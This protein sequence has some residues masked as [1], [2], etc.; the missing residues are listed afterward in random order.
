M[1]DEAA[2]P[3]RPATGEG[4]PGPAGPSP[5]SGPTPPPNSG[6]GPPPDPPP[7]GTAGFTTRYGLIRPR[8]GRYLAGVCAAIGRAT[9][10]DPILW[11]VLVAV[12]GFFG[13]IGI[14]VYV[15]AW[16]IIPGEGDTASPV[17]AM[18][19]RGRSSTSPVTVL[20]LGI[21]V[22]LGFGYVVTD[23]FRA[24]LL[25]AAILIGGAL[26]INRNTNRNQA[27][28]AGN[29]WSA[30]TGATSGPVPG[31][32]ATPTPTSNL[33]GSAYPSSSYPGSA[34]PGPTSAPGGQPPMAPPPPPPSGLGAT[35][36]STVPA[37]E[38]LSPYLGAASPTEPATLA[39]QAEP[40]APTMPVWPV[41]TSP[42]PPPPAVSPPPTGPLPPAGG[43]R[44]PFAPHGPYANATAYTPGM[45]PM[46]KPPRPP[47][48]PKERSP[49]GAATFSMI[50]VVLGLLA[51]LD[52]SGVISPPP[53]AY[54]AVALATIGLGLLIGTWFGRA[55]W[56]IALGLVAATALGI[57]T[58]A[59]SYDR[60]RN[61]EGDVTW[62]PS[63][64]RDLAIR[65]ENNFGDAVLD[66]TRIEFTDSETQVTAQVN[67]GNLTV[68]VPPN[69][70]VTVTASV[71]AGDAGVFNNRRSGVNIEQRDLTDLG[72]DGPG[73]GKLRLILYVN[74]GN[75]EVTR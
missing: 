4:T 25:G 21:L 8:Q 57:A 32:M 73:G 3:R 24:V 19:G 69:T 74:A 5:A 44:P 50:F 53:S 22:A 33:P 51:V 61:I 40:P 60:V 2:E 72:R 18:L 56:L 45:R 16:L 6:Y 1:T 28:E 27:T 10:T 31:P 29:P 12:L 39:G 23:A 14:L 47:K 54:F 66:L 42:A 11:R 65:Y 58:L 43:Y 48:P 9:N 41:G 52:L 64:Q 59:E 34:Y 15:A 46:V 37:T 7:P 63:N 38:P 35:G 30:G 70:D 55:R 67:F 36:P 13:G 17:E 49:L 71:N 75:L 68:L 26:L 20:V 62:T